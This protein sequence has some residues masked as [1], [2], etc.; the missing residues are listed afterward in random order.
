MKAAISKQFTVIAHIKYTIKMH[1]NKPNYYTNRKFHQIIKVKNL[2]KHHLLKKKSSNLEFLLYIYL[3]GWWKFSGTENH[4]PN[5]SRNSC[6]KCKISLHKK[7]WEIINFCLELIHF[8]LGEK[9]TIQTIDTI[10]KLEH[11]CHLNVYVVSTK[12][13]C[14]SF[15]TA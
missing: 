12:G 6:S 5:R 3:L 1:Q 8:I 4:A 11:I 14:F 13:I 7:V 2:H 15:W 9:V 10:K